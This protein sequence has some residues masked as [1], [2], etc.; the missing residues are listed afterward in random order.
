MQNRK[1]KCCAIWSSSP[2]EDSARFLLNRL[3]AETQRLLW[4][5]E[6]TITT[7][8]ISAS[9]GVTAGSSL[10]TYWTCSPDG[11][12]NPQS[13][14]SQRWGPSHCSEPRWPGAV[15]CSA[16]NLCQRGQRSKVRGT[17]EGCEGHRGY[18]GILCTLPASSTAI[19]IS[20]EL[21]V[22][23]LSTSLWR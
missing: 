2:Q 20:V 16:W 14:Q 4:R 5:T 17:R 9:V 18:Q 1:W 21:M 7:V 15:G 8:I 11:T 19:L 13:C 6:K 22:P 10:S 3:F 23:E 12:D